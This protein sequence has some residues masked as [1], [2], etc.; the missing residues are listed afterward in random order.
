[1]QAGSRVTSTE[2]LWA[3]R[4]ERGQPERSGEGEKK[5][6]KKRKNNLSTP[7]LIF[8]Q[9]REPSVASR[10]S[11]PPFSLFLYY[12]SPLP[13]PPLLPIPFNSL[14]LIRTRLLSS[15]AS[16]TVSVTAEQQRSGGSRRAGPAPR[17]TA[18]KR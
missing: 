9:T 17:R 11:A 13:L 14:P 5:N 3:L 15:P 2:R 7:S 18:I 8:I 4:K 16:P 10:A 12:P 1:M 6:T